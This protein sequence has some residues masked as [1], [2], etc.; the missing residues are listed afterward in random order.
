MQL[1]EHQEQTLV[2]RQKSTLEKGC[3]LPILLFSQ[4]PTDMNE[5][6]TNWVAAH[7]LN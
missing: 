5:Q 3:R 1:L 4:F 6:W 7:Y 2:Q